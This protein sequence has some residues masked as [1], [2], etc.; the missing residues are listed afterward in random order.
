MF[1]TG[2]QVSG[3]NEH[4]SWK[5]LWTRGAR[6]GFSQAGGLKTRSVQVAVHKFK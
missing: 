3:E 5:C 6:H 4:V 2:L 1:S